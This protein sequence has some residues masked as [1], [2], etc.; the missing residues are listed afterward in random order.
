MENSNRLEADHNKSNW[1]DYNY[2]NFEIKSESQVLWFINRMTKE[3]F[4]S[5]V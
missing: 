4:K 1:N 5:P 2:V 3:L